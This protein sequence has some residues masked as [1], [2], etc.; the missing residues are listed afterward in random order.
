[1]ASQLT[2]AYSQSSMS[3]RA[4]VYPVP[5]KGAKRYRRDAP[6]AA[7][8]NRRMVVSK[9]PRPMKVSG[10]YLPVLLQSTLKYTA[11]VQFATDGSGFGY[12]QFSCNGLYD[13]DT[14]GVGHQPLGF[15]QLM[16]I[17]NHYHVVASKMKVTGIR[18]GATNNL[19]TT[20]Y[21]DDD[22]TVSASTVETMAE[23]P[24]ART[25][26][27]W[28]AEGLFKSATIAYNAQAMFG[29]ETFG[30]DSLQGTVSANPTEGAFY[31][32]GCSASGS[33]NVDYFVEITYDCIFSELKSLSGS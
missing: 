25:V 16:A 15:D 12:Y 31:T 9:I 24:G 13:P 22:T 29:G 3:S 4:P 5:R 33:S 6:A 2:G 30:N 18:T 1:M 8:G 28:P 21:I 11:E 27:S 26:T 7:R 32:I 14:T 20:V 19:I 10:S 17:Y 23:R